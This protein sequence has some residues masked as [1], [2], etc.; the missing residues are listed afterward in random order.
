MKTL[1]ALKKFIPIV[2]CISF[3]LSFACEANKIKKEPNTYYF[4]FEIERI[5]GIHEDGID[6]NGCEYLIDENIFSSMLEP[7][8]NNISYN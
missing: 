5:T 2:L 4:G 3:P 7:L 1:D 6:K 8:A